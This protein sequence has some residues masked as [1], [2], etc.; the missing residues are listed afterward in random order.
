MRR[1]ALC[2]QDLRKVRN[3]RSEGDNMV[4][5]DGQKFALIK[6]CG[7]YAKD[8]G[9]RLYLLSQLL[10]RTINTSNDCTQ[11]DWRKIRNEAYQNWS[12]DDWSVCEP[13]IAKSQTICAKYEEE[14][15]GQARLF[16]RKEVSNG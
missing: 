7:N 5:T 13:F 3:I 15:M 4:M 8:R 16:P 11:E 6:L 1:E 10:G 2:R 9:Q 14:V 12:N